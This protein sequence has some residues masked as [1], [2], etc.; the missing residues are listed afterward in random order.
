V[1]NR[2]RCKVTERCDWYP[3]ARSHNI[4]RAVYAVKPSI[5]GW[6]GKVTC[7]VKIDDHGHVRVVHVKGT[8]DESVVKRIRAALIKWGVRACHN[9]RA[10][11]AR[12]R[13]SKRGMT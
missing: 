5:P 13:S 6:H 3:P 9:Q 4:S 8:T 1:E 11:V 10:P 12:I 7:G 2:K